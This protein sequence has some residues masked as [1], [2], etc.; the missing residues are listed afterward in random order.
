MALVH[1]IKNLAH[2]LADHLQVV[3]CILYNKLKAEV[4]TGVPVLL[5][6][7][8]LPVLPKLD[9]YESTV[10]VASFER[11][12]MQLYELGYQTIGTAKLLAWM[13]GKVRLP[14]KSVVITFDDGHLSVLK[15][16]LPVM[17]KYNFVATV[18]LTTE[19]IGND[20][21]K[22]VVSS[23]CGAVT[24][25]D[26]P[27]VLS[28]EEYGAMSWD[29]V[30]ELRDKGFEFGSHTR[31]HRVIRGLTNTQLEYEVNGAQ[32][33]VVENLGEL[34]VSFAYPCGMYDENAIKFLNRAPNLGLS[35]TVKFGTVCRNSDKHLLDRISVRDQDVGA[36][37]EAKLTGYDFRN[38]LKSFVRKPSTMCG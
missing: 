15:H 10:S 26:R 36:V 12:M 21:T 35:F 23:S 19:F 11:Q 6:H 32:R 4:D 3:P 16:A 34:P 8:I 38:Q 24:C 7:K 13:E 30:R 5:Y 22:K 1:T 2:S 20:S 27:S 31:N 37:F 14:E 18:F 29:Q 25:S 33:D 9:N 28:I 17:Q